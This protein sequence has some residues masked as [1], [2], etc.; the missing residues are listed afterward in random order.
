MEG[1]TEWVHPSQRTPE[2]KAEW[3]AAMAE[4]KYFGEIAEAEARREE[5]PPT[6][7]G[8]AVQKWEDWLKSSDCPFEIEVHTSAKH[9]T[10]WGDEIKRRE[11]MCHKLLSEDTRHWGIWH[12]ERDEWWRAGMSIVFSTTSWAVALAQLQVAR[13]LSAALDKK[14]WIVRCIEEWADERQT[15]T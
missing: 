11:A 13:Q 9:I 12:P 8:E 4:V 7:P 5:A 2:G 1:Q 6:T 14:R 15:E 10:E 3:D